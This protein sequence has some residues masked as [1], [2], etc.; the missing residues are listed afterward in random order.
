MRNILARAGWLAWVLFSAAFLALACASTPPAPAAPTAPAT[1]LRL[2]S[3]KWVPFT[4]PE[5]EPRVAL[6]LTEVALQRAGY[7]S[8]TAFVPDGQLTPKLEQGE[9][10][11][12]AA[13]WRSDDREQFLL[14]SKPYLENRLV[15]VARKGG[16][17]SARSLKDLKGKT[18]ALVDGYAYGQAVDSATETHFVRGASSR[19]NLQALLSGKVDY[20]LLDDLVVAYLFE[21]QAKDAKARLEAGSVPLVTRTLHLAVRKALPEAQQIIDRFNDAIASMVGDGS[22]NKA[23]Q[24]TWIRVDVDG[25]G[26]EELVPQ[27]DH[28]GAAPPE[29]SYAL[30]SPATVAAATATVSPAIVTAAPPAAGARLETSNE[31]V[32][33][34]VNGRFYDT[35]QEVPEKLRGEPEPNYV[36]GGKTP[37]LTVEF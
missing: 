14:Y 25:D 37:L 29:R 20:V 23:L 28:L 30:F 27:G 34:Y 10:D 26:K 2:V 22:Y 5:G 6:S 21:Q 12:S 19:D 11:G 3:T 1:K 24:L 18:V 15:L 7:E 13:L 36:V 35:W 32:R 16:D 31:R 33:Y 9:F 17:V 8:T 4:A